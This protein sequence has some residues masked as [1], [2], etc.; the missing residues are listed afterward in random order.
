MKYFEYSIMCEVFY[1]TPKVQAGTDIY[2]EMKNL[3]RK[4]IPRLGG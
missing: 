4:T 3:Q 1:S 2:N